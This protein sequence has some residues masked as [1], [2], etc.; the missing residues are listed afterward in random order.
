MVKAWFLAAGAAERHLGHKNT[1]SSVEESL[2][3][4]FMAEEAIRAICGDIGSL[5]AYL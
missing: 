1:N 5:G 3:D 2:M 4:G